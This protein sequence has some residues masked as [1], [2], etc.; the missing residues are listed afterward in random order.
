M[1]SEFK[2]DEIADKFLREKKNGFF[3]DI[4]AS[5]YEKWNNTYFFEKERDY[6]G[7]AVEMNTEFATPWA[8]HRPNTI[9]YNEDATKIN[10]KQILQDAKAPAIIDFLSVDIDPNTATW[11]SLLKVMDTDHQFNVIAFEVDYGGDLQNKDRFSVRDPSRAYLSARGYVLVCELF[12]NGG[13]YHVDDIWV[14]KSIYD[15]EIEKSL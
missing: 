8:E 12:A 1:S 5:Y 10:Y 11:E 2:Q 13:A 14:H 15:Y 7:I 4:G 9:M 3:V 6:R